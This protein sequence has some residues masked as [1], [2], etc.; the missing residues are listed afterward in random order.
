MQLTG[1]K[2]LQVA[3]IATVTGIVLGLVFYGWLPSAML[4]WGMHVPRLIGVFLV[5]AIGL[6]ISAFLALIVS[7][8]PHIVD[9]SSTSLVAIGGVVV[10]PAV[11][12]VPVHLIAIYGN[13]ENK[14]LGLTSF[15]FLSGLLLIALS[16]IFRYVEQNYVVGIRDIWTLRSAEV[17]EDT[18]RWASVLFL[19]FGVLGVALTW[20]VPYGFLQALTIVGLFVVPTVISVLYSYTIRADRYQYIVR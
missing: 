19:I 2:A 15:V 1:L 13:I 6:A 3:A 14:V 4:V 16:I 8:D 10:L 11:F 12:S 5:P 7:C 17:W 9:H 18:H 20:I